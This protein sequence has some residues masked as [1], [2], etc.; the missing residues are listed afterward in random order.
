[1]KPLDK[2]N[3]FN[4]YLFH[5]GKHFKAYEFMGA[6]VG[7]AGT[8]FTVWAPNAGYVSLVGNF[9][10]WDSG[11]T[12]LEKIN[13]VGL[14]W[15]FVPGLGEYEVYKYFIVGPGGEVHYK[16]DPYGFF[17]EVKPQTASVTFDLEGYPW[18]DGEWMQARRDFDFSRSPIAV[19]E[20]NA[21]SWRKNPDGSYYGYHQLAEELIPH[22]QELG[23]T[24][25]ELMP[26]LEH[27]FDGSWGYQVTGYFAITSRYGNPKDFMFFVDRCHQAGIGVIFDWVPSHYCKDA[28]GL[29]HFDGGGVY[30][31]TDPVLRENLDW[32]TFNF[33]YARD[34]VRSFLISSANF[35]FEKFHVDGF[36]VDAVA[37]MI[38]KGMSTSRHDLFH[39]SEL[40]T[41]AIAFLKEL[42]TEVFA[43]HP[44]ILMIAE[45][46]SAYPLVTK[47]VSTGGL[48]FNLKWNMGWMH[49]TL[50]YLELDPLYRKEAHN[51][52]TFSIA[53]AFSENF[54]LPLSHDEVV[55]GKKSLLDKMV[56]G[57]EEKFKGLKLL[58]SYQYFHPGKK[59]TFMG[60]ELAQF[61]E[62]DEWGTLDWH[63]LDYDSHRGVFNYLKALNHS[64]R[65]LPPLHAIDFEYEGFKWNDVENARESVISFTR[66]DREGNTLLAVMNFTPVHREGYWIKVHTRED[67][68]IILSSEEKSYGGA[69]ESIGRVYSPF[70]EYGH[71]F[72]AMDLPP[73]C[74][75]LLKPRKRR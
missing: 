34:E 38:Y 35:L 71:H 68:E 54:L 18:Q 6:Q 23:Y 66:Y 46:S 64:Y 59:L 3:E 62:W 8:G 10:G 45:E 50:E 55:H 30:E 72:I 21:A 70:E 31:K 11:A 12:P 27:P 43:R 57:Y 63:L 67:Q 75:I 20:L 42:N 36:R 17:A 28:H 29:G 16:A 2:P 73:L 74:A 47:P 61:V 40:N 15:G 52:L 41:E 13:E 24:H 22:I 14:W 65:N 7:K 5:E 39:H 4:Q 37:Y 49:D 26:L 44:G 32:G 33:D 25:I 9:N 58:L 19:Y 1:M 60:T 69:I 48:G 53:Y 56:G 51:R